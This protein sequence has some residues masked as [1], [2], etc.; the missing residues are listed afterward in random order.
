ME[1]VLVRG[2]EDIDASLPP[3]SFEALVVHEIKLEISWS[4][5]LPHNIVKLQLA[6]VVVSNLQSAIVSHYLKHS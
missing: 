6:L 3:W 5:I 1:W 4:H 2:L